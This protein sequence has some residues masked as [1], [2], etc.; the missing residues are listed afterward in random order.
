MSTAF[1]KEDLSLKKIEQRT[2]YGTKRVRRSEQQRF[3]PM[4]IIFDFRK[5]EGMGKVLGRSLLTGWQTKIY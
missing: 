3:V 1:G 2:G 5:I 4:E